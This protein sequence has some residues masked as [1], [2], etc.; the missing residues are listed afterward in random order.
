MRLL[1]HGFLRV[2]YEVSCPPTRFPIFGAGNPTQNLGNCLRNPA[3]EAMFQGFLSW[4]L[5]RG[6]KPKMSS[7]FPSRMQRA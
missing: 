3:L 6:R 4:K 5:F 7:W 1:L 2:S